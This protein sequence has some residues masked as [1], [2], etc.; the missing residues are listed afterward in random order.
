MNFS[1]VLSQSRFLQNVKKFGAIALSSKKA[2]LA[3]GLFVRKLS[4]YHILL[5]VIIPSDQ[6]F[7]R[8]TFS[9]LIA[10]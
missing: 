5:T 9:S 8:A 3:Q 2:N 7:L 4:F 10:D 6:N 1:L